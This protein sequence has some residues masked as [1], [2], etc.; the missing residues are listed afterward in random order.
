MIYRVALV[1]GLLL[2]TLL[3]C[4]GDPFRFRITAYFVDPKELPHTG[5]KIRVEVEATQGD[6]AEV[7]VY[8][9]LGEQGVFQFTVRLHPVSAFDFE[10]KR[11]KGEVELPRN[12]TSEDQLYVLVISVRNKDEVDERMVEVIVKGK[13][14]TN[15]P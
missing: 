12:N 1:S 6:R 10:K 5:G 14:P 11:W 15:N 3:G 13:P 4:S 2:A 8:R 7:K 9:K